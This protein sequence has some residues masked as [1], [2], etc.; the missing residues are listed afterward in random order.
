MRVTALSG[1]VRGA[2]HG[3]SQR[4]ECDEDESCFHCW[5]LSLLLTVVDNASLNQGPCFYT[6]Q[7]VVG[8]FIFQEGYDCRF[9]LR[10]HHDDL[11]RKIIGIS[12]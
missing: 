6:P 2:L 8:D 12:S 1:V 3:N 5:L 4:G 10:R 7:A 11:L 9:R